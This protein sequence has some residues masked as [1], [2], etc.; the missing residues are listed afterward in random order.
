MPRVM[1]R[2]LYSLTRRT[3]VFY[4][5]G[6]GNEDRGYE[7]DLPVSIDNIKSK[8]NEIISDKNIASKKGED[9]KV[10]V[11]KTYSLTNTFKLYK[12]LFTNLHEEEHT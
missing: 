7:L 2:L 11:T 12:N 9:G 10:F 8:I 3:Y 6:R 4:T 1:E 5:Y